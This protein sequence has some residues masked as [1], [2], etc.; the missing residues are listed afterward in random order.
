MNNTK[1]TL[2]LTS[3][4]ES[5]LDCI[6]GCCDHDCM[7]KAC[8]F[9]KILSAMS[10]EEKQKELVLRWMKNVLKEGAKKPTRTTK[11][12]KKKS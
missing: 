12:V 3:N 11:T 7:D 4:Q 9:N 10:P 2:R 5:I 1:T 8:P 6:C